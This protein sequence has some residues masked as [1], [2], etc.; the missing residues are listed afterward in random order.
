MRPYYWWA[1]LDWSN[2]MEGSVSVQLLLLF[3][4]MFAILLWGVSTGA[5]IIRML[6]GLLSG[7]VGLA[8]F[9]ASVGLIWVGQ[10]AHWTSDGPGMLLIMVAIPVFGIV[11]VVFSSVALKAVF[12]NV[13]SPPAFDRLT[14]AAQ[15]KD[16]SRMDAILYNRMMAW[17]V[18]G[19]LVLFAANGIY[20]HR[21]RKPSHDARV[22]AMHT[23]QP[24]GLATL[25]AK[26]ILKLWGVSGHRTSRALSVGAIPAVLVVTPDARVAFV[27]T[28]QHQL[29]IFDL[30]TSAPAGHT[31]EHVGDVCFEGGDSVLAIRDRKVVRVVASTAPV[32][33][34]LQGPGFASVLTCRADTGEI[35]YVDEN[36]VLH[37][38]DEGTGHDRFTLPLSVRPVR[39][40]PSPEFHRLLAIAPGGALFLIDLATRQEL[41]LPAHHRSL[42]AGFLSEDQIVIGEVSSVRVD[43]PSMKSMP[44]F[45]LGQPVTALATFPSISTT[46]VAFDKELYLAHDQKGSH[47]GMAQTDRLSDPRF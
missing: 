35:V 44:Y 36:K 11:G 39:L 38:F 32:A 40:I 14:Q 42:H 21:A 33:A 22:L 26:G 23:Y 13:S 1:R 34:P 28:K 17:I 10:K 30:A 24:G 25:D 41:P 19:L 6:A 20:D 45:N 27:L 18:G 46:V 16:A 43:I 31:V 4:I 29:R 37:L 8:G 5:S 12:S 9:A 47:S 2:E 3:L 15:A 7:M